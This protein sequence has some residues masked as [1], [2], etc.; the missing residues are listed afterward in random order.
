MINRLKNPIRARC[1][2]HTK[3]RLNYVFEHCAEQSNDRSFVLTHIPGKENP[4][5]LWTKVQ[6]D[7]ADFY[8]G[9]KYVL[10]LDVLKPKY[11]A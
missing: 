10:N 4:A 7:D 5:D 6:P 8:F 2:Q 9:R 11:E 1:K 3:L